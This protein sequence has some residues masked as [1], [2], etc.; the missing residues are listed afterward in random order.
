L[1]TILFIIFFI[2]Y[3]SQIGFLLSKNQLLMYSQNILTKI[4]Q[5]GIYVLFPGQLI[6]LKMRRNLKKKKKIDIIYF[7][8]M[9]LIF[10]SS[11][12]VGVVNFFSI[13]ITTSYIFSNELKGVYRKVFLKEKKREKYILI[14]VL[15]A[16]ILAFSLNSNIKELSLV[17]EKILI[18]ML[19]FGDIYFMILP[20]DKFALIEKSS[21]L[22][23]YFWWILGPISLLLR[24]EIQRPITIGF[25]AMK[26]VYNMENPIWGP[27]TRFDI[28]YLIFNFKTY[29]IILVSFFWGAFLS[30]TRKKELFK[31]LIFRIY[32]RVQL[33]FIVGNIL[34]DMSIFV[35][36]FLPLIV[37]FP[38]L[39][40]TTYFMIKLRS[41]K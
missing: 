19:A 9:F 10:F 6:L 13:L 32:I 34:T 23:Y 39:V 8:M 11:G 38:T 26:I 22:K 29:Q 7:I 3:C 24:L 17:L 33:I 37:I 20:Q 28:L 30:F 21:F 27:N 14:I 12:K 1:H 16:L 5:F 36:F 31:S 4:I 40:L 41:N 2:L 15:L 25:E 18:R 35:A